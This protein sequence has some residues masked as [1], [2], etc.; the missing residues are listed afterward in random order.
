MENKEYSLELGGR[1]LTLKFLNWAEQAQG[2]LLVTYGDT[3]VL[4]TAVMGNQD[5]PLPYFPLTVEYRER[6]YAAGKIGG[7]RF[8]K[9]EG[10]PSD[11]STLKAR[12]IDRALRPLFNN[13]MRR[14]VQI[15]NNIFSYDSQNMPDI[16]GLIGSSMA[17]FV[18]E[19]PWAG[20]I[21]AVRV[22]R[23]DNSWVLN[24]SAEAQE[25]S[26]LNLTITGTTGKI[27]MIEV[28]AQ[29]ASEEDITEA[30][31][32]GAGY[33]EQIIEF[34]K[35]I[36]AEIGA[37]K[38]EVP[39][40]EADENL[41]K[42]VREFAGSRLK[43][44]LV[45]D[46]NKGEENKLALLNSELKKHLQ[47]K[48][49]EGAEEIG[50][51]IDYLDAFGDEVVHE[52]A[53][54]EN[55][56]VDGRKFDEV[57]DLSASIG[58]LPRTHG[59]AVFMRGLT[60]A[61]SVVTLASPGNE[62]LHDDMEGES[63]KSFMHHYNFPPFSTGE[64]GFFRGPGRREIGHGALAEKALTPLI[65]SQEKFPYVIRLVSEI[66]SSNGSSSM[67]SVCGSSLALMDAGVPI[68]GHIA[69]IAMGLI[70]SS[71][72]GEYKVLTDIQGPEDHHGDMDLKV[73]G[74]R[75]G[76][77]AMQMDVKIDGVSLEVLK[78]AIE[79]A[80]KARDHILTMLEGA[81]VQP[82]EGLSP[83]AP[84]IQVLKINPERIGMLIG[85][86]GR[87]IKEIMA[88][89]ETEINVEE[90]GSVFISG[91]DPEKVKKAID[92][93]EGITHEIEVGE[94]FKAKVV[95]I[96][97]FGAFVELTPGQ[98]ALVHVSELANDYVKD[99]NDV[100]KM[101]DLIDVKVIKVDDQGKISA[102]VKQL[103]KKQEKGSGEQKG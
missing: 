41:K 1:T 30:I 101:G 94:V 100:V 10:R 72:G 73:A 66:L 54:K 26:D 85:A 45:Q 15:V 9:R 65:P 78:D 29:E 96:A 28:A 61:L 76:V 102:S 33:I 2:S 44:A 59:S 83:Y 40:L 25:K 37:K 42:E 71:D 34:Q 46:K 38:T 64:T 48:Y 62:E 63:K 88:T 84:I 5:K 47:E 32:F 69:G 52:L 12:L 75:E 67:A 87:T 27:N 99:V 81:I 35:K 80:K 50:L 20:P 60:H 11:E 51:G 91:T 89:T 22:G 56:R 86:G 13:S 8:M 103:D 93:A 39:L 43:E 70:A 90:D 74:T 4:T 24:P 57:R 82:R 97:D 68:K 3:V 16:L 31:A 77:T 79:A 36:Q 23:V 98:D 55:K 19:I 21:G 53:L 17:L 14:E 18:S 92:W 6:Y 95:R 49:G 7:G 58:A